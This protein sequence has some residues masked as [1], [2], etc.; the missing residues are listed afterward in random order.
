MLARIDEVV[1]S[2][3]GTPYMSGQQVKGPDGAVDCVRFGCG[4]LDELYG[5]RR[6]L[7]RNLPLDTAFHDR[8]AAM[9]GMR[10]LLRLYPELERV[11]ERDDEGRLIVEPSDV[12]AT[13]PKH[14]GPGHLVLV[15]VRP[16]TCWEASHPRVR[17][18]G[19]GLD[20]RV[21]HVFRVYRAR[22]RAR[23]VA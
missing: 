18:I 11:E 5:R 19:V 3:A 7:P 16:N 9:A 10:R 13:G 1:R 2:W 14:G 6:E 22:D 8:E 17:E 15:G 20:P 4:V 21:M 23:W 12:L